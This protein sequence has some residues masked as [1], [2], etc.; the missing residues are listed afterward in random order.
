LIIVILL[1]LLLL[2]IDNDVTEFG[3]GRSAY[4]NYAS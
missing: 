3:A 1:L 2:V 4:L